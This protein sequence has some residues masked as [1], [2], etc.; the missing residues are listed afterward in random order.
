MEMAQTHLTFPRGEDRSQLMVSELSQCMLKE[1]SAT[2]IRAQSVK[3][4]ASPKTPAVSIQ[5]QTFFA[6]AASQAKS[7]PRSVPP[8]QHRSSIQSSNSLDTFPA[9][10]F[11]VPYSTPLRQQYEERDAML[12]YDPSYF[13]QV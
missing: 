2:R 12:V 11:S 10:D 9:Y 5:A 13:T 8:K 3:L 7:P 4:E 1:D 6:A